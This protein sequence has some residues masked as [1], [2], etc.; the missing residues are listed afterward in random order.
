MEP[1][2]LELVATKEIIDELM[3]RTTFQ[4]VVIH[5][6]GECKTSDWPEKQVFK[7]HFSN[8]LSS[9]EAGRLLEIVAGHL[10]RQEG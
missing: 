1:S 4:G 10:D 8:S 7:V 6:Q 2:A 3:R 9:D 5:S